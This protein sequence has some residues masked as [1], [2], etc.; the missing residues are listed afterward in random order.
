MDEEVKQEYNRSNEL[1]K[2]YK[3]PPYFDYQLDWPLVVD[4]LYV[5]SDEYNFP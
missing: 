2:E 1:L 3:R 5:K 4:G